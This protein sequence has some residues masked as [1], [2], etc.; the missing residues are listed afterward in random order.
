MRWVWI[1]L[2]GVL[3]IAAAAGFIYCRARGFDGFTGHIEAVKGPGGFKIGVKIGCYK[4]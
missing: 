1:I 2:I 3:V 4:G